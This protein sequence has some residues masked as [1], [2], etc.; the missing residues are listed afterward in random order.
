MAQS[1]KEQITEE[2][3]KTKQDKKVVPIMTMP[4]RPD[5]DI[6]RVL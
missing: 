2:E 4:T 6:P 5:I 1:D 3:E